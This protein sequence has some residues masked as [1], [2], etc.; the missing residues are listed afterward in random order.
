[1]TMEIGQMEPTGIPADIDPAHEAQYNLRIR[2]P[3][4]TEIYRNYAQRGMRTRQRTEAVLDLR[5]GTRKTSI[6]DLFIPKNE[7]T[8]PLLIFI[9]GGY[10]RAL[11]KHDFSFIADAYLAQGVAVAMPNYDLAPLA[12]VSE[13]VSQVCDSVLWLAGQGRRFGYDDNRIVISGHSAGGNMARSE[14]HTSEL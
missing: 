3:E 8:P 4:R 12:T 11:D 10:W 13:I 14:E 9:H 5:Y 7:A 1:M 2:H 6:L